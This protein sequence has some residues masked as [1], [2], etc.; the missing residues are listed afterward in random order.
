MPQACLL[1][2]W[3]AWEQ[4]AGPLVGPRAGLWAM[5]K[6]LRRLLGFNSPMGS[7]PMDPGEGTCLFQR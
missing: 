4:L 1:P 3:A 7:L 6:R 2:S 5:R